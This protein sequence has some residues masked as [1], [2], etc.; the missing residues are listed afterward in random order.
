MALGGQV[1]DVG[2]DAADRRRVDLLITEL[3]D[4]HGRPDDPGL[5]RRARGHGDSLPPDARDA[6][7]AMRYAQ[8]PAALVVRAGQ[9]GTDEPTPAHWRERAPGATRRQD[10][11]LL[12]LLAV[13]G[14]PVCWSSLQD[15]R[16]FND[17]LPIRGEEEEQTGHGSAAELAFHVD[18][19]FSGHRCDA[20]GLLCLRNDDAVATTVASLDAS[21]L[22]GLDLDALY[23][24]V[25]RIVPDEEHLRGAAPGAHRD[26]PLLPVLSGSREAPCLRV[27]PACTRARPGDARARR[28]LDDL[29][30]CLRSRLVDVLLRP[31][32]VLI[33]DNGRA[34][35][36]RASFRAR[37]DGTDRWLR[38]LTVTRDLR[39]SRDSRDGVDGRVVTPF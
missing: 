14:D 3:L 5:L 37:Y 38:K 9:P 19:A 8:G 17:V 20:L 10:V 12:L 31:G 23:E 13:L 11:W 27:D 6:L 18:D 2:V 25:F 35:H 32:D 15:G 33:I 34:V 30:R 29:H 24:P 39:R 7:L 26:P 22:P 21:D 4:R 1:R 36:G 28:A 16:L